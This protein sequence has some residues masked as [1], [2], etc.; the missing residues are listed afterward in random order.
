MGQWGPHFM[1]RERFVAK[2]D[3]AAEYQRKQQ[4]ALPKESITE[5]GSPNWLVPTM[6]ALLVVGLVWIVTT[7][8]FQ[9]RYPIPGLGQWNLAIGIVII[10]SG[11]G[12]ATRWK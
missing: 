6:I 1:T 9:S 4:K 2:A 5:E 7:Y 8:L 11:F 10:L 12:L 3:K